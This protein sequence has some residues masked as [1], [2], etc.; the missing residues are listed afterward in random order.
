LLTASGWP[1]VI[2]R[3]KQNKEMG[4]RIIVFKSKG[5]PQISQISQ[6]IRAG[7]PNW[8]VL[9]NLQVRDYF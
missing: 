2:I 4:V 8:L 6:M 9:L 7:F 3:V 1:A 5:G